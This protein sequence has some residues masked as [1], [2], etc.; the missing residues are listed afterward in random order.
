MICI[1][2]HN[3]TNRISDFGQAR[4]IKLMETSMTMTCGV[5]SPFYVAPEIIMNDT[6]YTKAVDVFSFAIMAAQVMV[7]RLV[8][9]A[10]EFTT[11]YGL[12]SKMVFSSQSTQLIS[13]WFL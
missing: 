9:N 12:C 6:H 4:K 5:G 11:E 10:E 13:S 1:T 2:T 7:G 3:T 8:F